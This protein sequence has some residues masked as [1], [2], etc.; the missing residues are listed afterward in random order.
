MIKSLLP[1]GRAWRATADNNLRQFLDGV[2]GF[3]DDAV[4]FVDQVWQDGFPSTTRDLDAW[5]HQFALP[6][7]GLTTQ[8]RRDRLAA[9]WKTLGGQDPSYLQTALQDA[10]F[11][12]YVHE[13]WVPGSEPAI[14]VNASATPRNPNTYIRSER[15]APYTVLCGEPLAQCGEPD[16]LCGEISAPAGYLLVNKIVSMEPLYIMQCGEPL[17][18]CG[19]PDALCGNFLGYREVEKVYGIS[20][21]PDD[22]PYYLYIG[23]STFGTNATVPTSRRD[24]FEELCLK[25]CP[26]QQAL[27]IM[28]TYT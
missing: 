22:W 18:Q 10:G 25:I 17:A 20:L 2:E 28:V 13:W 26:A 3:K 1:R 4:T 23:A 27:G 12:V 15:D 9:T 24:E 19:E 16:A 7:T 8:E 11:D 21:D 14:G 6:D 5:E